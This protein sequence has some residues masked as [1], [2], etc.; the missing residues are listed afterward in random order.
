MQNTTSTQSTKQTI[1]NI[2]VIISLFL[3]PIIG[4]LLMWLLASWSRKIKVIITVFLAILFILIPFIIWNYFILSRIESA[5]DKA[6]IAVIESEIK[7]AE[8]FLDMYYEENNEYPANLKVLELWTDLKK[9]ELGLSSPYPLRKAPGSQG[10]D[11]QYI[12]ERPTPYQ[13]H[14]AGKL[15]GELIYEA[16]RTR[17]VSKKSYERTIDW[18]EEL[19]FEVVYPEDI[20]TLSREGKKVVMTHSIPFEHPD[21]CDFRGDAPPLKE[22]TDFKVSIEVVNKNLR[23]TVI[24]NESNYLVSNFLLD[25]KLKIT[26]N[27]IDEISIGLLKGYRITSGVEGCGQYTYY[28]PLSPQ[29]TLVVVRSFITELQPI[30]ADY[31]KYLELPGI[32]PPSEEE[33]LFYQIL[34][35][36]SFL[37]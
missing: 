17:E 22:L 36:F 10:A 9:D 33:K 7:N 30:V 19:G 16:S 26:P 3:I 37:E 31:E 25:N 15:N 28:F 20:I 34:S 12:Y 35:T 8:V 21:P 24:A 2:L 5:K 13:Y 1:I 4:L 29:N 18:K 27:F 32:I 23:D 6:K 11:V 14:L